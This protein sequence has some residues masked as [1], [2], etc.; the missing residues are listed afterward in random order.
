MEPFLE[1]CII[2]N[3]WQSYLSWYFLCNLGSLKSWCMIWNLSETLPA[4]CANGLN[5]AVDIVEF[6][7]TGSCHS[8]TAIS[9]QMFS[10]FTIDSTTCPTFIQFHHLEEAGM[11]PTGLSSLILACDLTCS[12]VLHFKCIVASCSENFV[13]CGLEQLCGCVEPVAAAPH[14]SPG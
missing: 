8:P 6:S 2:Y 13:Y 1:L 3:L 14:P 12:E 4:K 5:I 11:C 10:N 7:C 9:I